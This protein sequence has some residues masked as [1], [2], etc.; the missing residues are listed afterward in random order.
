MNTEN[1]PTPIPPTAPHTPLRILVVGTGAIG[2]YYG[3]Q[4]A[5]AGAQ[6]T[7][8][9]RSDFAAV[10]DQGIHIDGLRGSYHFRPA[11]VLRRVADYDGFP[12]YILVC[13]K[14]LGNIDT[15]EI[16]RP[17]VGPATTIVLLQNGVEIEEEVAKKFP[18]NE[19]LSGLAF[20]CLSRT[21]PGHI[22]HTCYGHLTIGRYPS[23]PSQAAERL[24]ETFEA[25]GTDCPVT[26]TIAWERWKKLVWNAAFNPISVLGQATTREILSH[27]ATAQLVRRTM[28]EVCCIATAAGYPLT[29]AIVQKNLDA[30]QRIKPYK[31]SML[32]DYLSGRSMEVEAILGNAIQVAKRYQVAVPCLETVYALLSLFTQ[33]LATRR[34]DDSLQ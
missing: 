2:G 1:T 10:R 14:V 12:D 7:T 31:T 21:T 4:L 24:A 8:V 29:D 3:A 28:T 22:S 6:V 30:T 25:A 34:Q 18:H 13:L 23:G 19:L 11:Q 27:P 16:I 20:V 17:A 33:Q 32:L 26:E 15:A 5:K 9:H